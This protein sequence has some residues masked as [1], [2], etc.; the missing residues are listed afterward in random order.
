MW[1]QAHSLISLYSQPQ[2]VLRV[3]LLSWLMPSFKYVREI[4]AWQCSQGT[5]V[6]VGSTVLPCLQCQRVLWNRQISCI[7]AY[8]IQCSSL[9]FV[10]RRKLCMWF[11][12]LCRNHIVPQV[13]NSLLQL[14]VCW[15]VCRQILSVVWREA[16]SQGSYCNLV[17]L[18][19]WRW[20]LSIL[21]V[22]RDFQVFPIVFYDTVEYLDQPPAPLLIIS[23]CSLST[24]GDF[25]SWTIEIIL[26]TSGLGIYTLSVG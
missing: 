26:L 15:A 16:R 18:P 23:G 5:L 3:L 17:C 19:S 1:Q 22:C 25:Q 12:S 10:T 20:W 4:Q 24:P 9:G 13:E 2:I 8:S 21:P 11:L 7:G 14:I 6:S